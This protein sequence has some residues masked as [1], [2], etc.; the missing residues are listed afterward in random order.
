M[1]AGEA[2]RGARAGVCLRARARACECQLP[3]FLLPSLPPSLPSEE[4]L[5]GQAA[6]PADQRRAPAPCSQRSGEHRPA[7][8]LPLLPLR[9]AGLARAVPQWAERKPCPSKSHRG[10]GLAVLRPERGTDP[11][12]ARGPV[13]GQPARGS[14]AGMPLDIQSVF[15]G[16]ALRVRADRAQQAFY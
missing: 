7:V 9:A 15:W 6:A 4:E 14:A 2:R 8:Q 12:S 1:L 10:Q 11:L 13:T 3:P 16:A 5:P